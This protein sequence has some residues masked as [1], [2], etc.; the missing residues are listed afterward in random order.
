MFGLDLGFEGPNL[1]LDQG[2]ERSRFGLGSGLVLVWV[3]V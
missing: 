3:C 1:G 2:F